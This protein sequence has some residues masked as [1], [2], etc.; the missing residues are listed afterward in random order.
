M[1]GLLGTND[2]RPDVTNLVNHLDAAHNLARWLLRNTSET[3]DVVQEAYVRAVH[4]YHTFR[5]NNTRP[6]LLAIVRNACYDWMRRGRPSRHDR[7]LDEMATLKT[8]AP[9]AEARLLEQEDA[10]TLHKALDRLPA[11]LREV[12]VLREFED[13]RYREIAQL[14]G[15]PVGTVMSRLSRARKHLEGLLSESR[16]VAVETASQ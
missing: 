11:H 9:S 7:A 8:D 4:A 14:A 12:L 10:A 6:W 3:E 16:F 5:G 15:I 2:A 1:F 13:L